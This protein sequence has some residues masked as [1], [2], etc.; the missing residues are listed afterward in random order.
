ML[1]AKVEAQLSAVSG[2]RHV[3]AAG[4]ITKLTPPE[5]LQ[6]SVS[7]PCMSQALFWNRERNFFGHHFVNYLGRAMDSQR[8]LSDMRDAE[9]LR[10]IS[11][12]DRLAF[13]ALVE[14]YGGRV[15]SFIQR[16]VSDS[17]VAED[18]L[19]E[20][21]L[22]VYRKRNTV[23]RVR[24]FPSWIFAIAA[25]LARD[26]LRRKK[27]RVFCQDPLAIDCISDNSNRPDV[28]A[29][30]T[31]LRQRIE[32]S[33]QALPPQQKEVLVLRDIE[34]LSYEQIGR[35]LRLRMGTV[36]SRLNRARLRL[37]QELRPYL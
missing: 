1:F 26:E 21:F 5:H 6:L 7:F 12:D 24:S 23:S 20:T 35:I 10:R 37:Q 28:N 2:D 13:N 19:Q 16:M 17:S 32:A 15:H 33:I 4:G 31:E 18:I 14:R 27:S 22:R 29:E 8:E 36:K 9:L 3:L 30:K 11:S 34:G 25:N